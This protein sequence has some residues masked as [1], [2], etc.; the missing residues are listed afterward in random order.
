MPAAEIRVREIAARLKHPPVG[1]PAFW[2]VQ[3]MVVVL[4]VLHLV[5]DL[6]SSSGQGSF[7]T[8]VPVGLLL[9]PVGYAALRYGLSGSAATA[10]WAILLWLPDLALPGGRGHP[11]DDVVELALVLGVA[12]FAGI[13]VER[14]HLQRERARALEA[15]SR[16]AERRFAHQLLRAQEEERTRI[17]RDLHDDPV[18]RLIQLARHLESGGGYGARAELLEVVGR[19]RELTRG[20]RPAGIDELGLVAALRGMLDSVEVTENLKTVIDVT[21]EPVRLPP[22]TELGLFRIAQEAVG[23]AV[24]HAAPSHVTIDVEFG[25]EWLTMAVGDDGAGF[26]PAEAERRVDGHFGLRGMRERAEL[27]GGTLDV[28][29]SQGRG[30]VVKAQVPLG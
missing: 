23:N 26:D 6:Q 9:L 10:L 20:L 16:A 13:Y 18:Q 25:R 5:V 11:D 28:S 19:L 2:V 3:A 22:D 15:E 27:I 7:P 8:G 12:I 30:T 21:G 4:A 1:E 14:E 24:R 17:A 29:S